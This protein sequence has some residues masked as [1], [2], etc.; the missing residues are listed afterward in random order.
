MDTL[1]TIDSLMLAGERFGSAMHIGVVL[2]FSFPDGA[3]PQSYLDEFFQHGLL[4]D[5]PIDARLRRHPHRGSD[6][7]GVWAWREVADIDL[8]EHVYRTT[9]TPGSGPSGLWEMVSELHSGRLDMSVPLWTSHLIDGLPDGRFALYLKVHHTLLDGTAALGLL[10]AALSGDADRREM[11]PIY[12]AKG[13]AKGSGKT[14]KAS[15]AGKAGRGGRPTKG[16]DSGSA[17]PAEATDS[18]TRR[19]GRRSAVRA[20]ADAAAAGLDLTRRVATA[21][22]ANILGSMVTDA[23]VPPFDAPRT[24]FNAKLGNR[25]TA[26]GISLDHK[27]IDAIRKAAGVSGDDVVTALIAGA[28]RAWLLERDQL[29]ERTLVAMCGLGLCPLGTDIAD[30]AER[31]EFIALA[32]KNIRTQVETKGSGAM[33]AVTGPA[34]GSTVV[35]PRLPFGSL[36]RPSCNMA[37]SNVTGPRKPMYYNGA[38]L[39]EIYPLSTV[40]DG[41]GLNAT[42]CGYTDQVGI[43][44]VSGAEVMPRIAELVPLTEQALSELEAAVGVG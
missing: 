5:R 33:L 32:M 35:L 12:A 26:A 24:R 19:G 42:V 3:D 15:K 1:E 38:H 11:A 37:I 30:P 22:V 25:R 21:E 44:Y 29:P 16:D 10:G 34:V 6:T 31:L 9:L 8:G 39:D 4:T 17:D 14:G 27:R 18:G 43:G 20:V 7:G 13:A 28:L 41:M 23:V 2:I 40:Y 36:V